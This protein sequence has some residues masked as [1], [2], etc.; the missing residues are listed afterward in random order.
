MQNL[1]ES[2]KNKLMAKNQASKSADNE[3]IDLLSLFYLVRDKIIWII[4]FALLGGVLMYAY[5]SFFI[6]PLYS[7]T[8]I[9]Y[10]SNSK[11]VAYAETITNN[12]ISMSKKLVPTYQAIV[13]TKAAMKR[14]IEEM[15]IEGYTP[16]ELVSMVSTGATEDTGMLKITVT[17]EDQFYVADIA[18]AVAEVGTLEISKYV[19]GSTVSV[20]DRAVMPQSKT[21]PSNSRNAMLGAVAGAFLCAAVIVLRYLMTSVIKKSEELSSI[22]N[23]PV[24]GIIPNMVAED[25]G[26]AYSAKNTGGRS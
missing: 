7:A 19:E 21:Y 20:I 14:V 25:E 18:N 24:L 22:L 12:E 15:G 23:A 3:Q 26:G 10:V 6:T 13:S 8:A 1:V 2:K 9:V 4:A 5:S 11:T 16:A 17:G